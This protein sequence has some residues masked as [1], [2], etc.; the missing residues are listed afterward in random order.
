M[1]K[2]IVWHVAVAPLG[3]ALFFVAQPVFALVAHLVVN[4]CSGATGATGGTGPT[5]VT[6]GTGATG[7]TGPTGP[8]GATGAT[9]GTGGTGPTGA[10]GSSAYEVAVAEGFVGD[11]AAW[12]ASLVGPTGATGAT[13]ATGGTG[14]TGST[15]ATGATGPTGP[16]GAT[17]AAG[18]TGAT[19]ATGGAAD[20]A[21]EIH[22]ATSKAT[23][24]DADELGL[25]DSAAANGLKKLTWANL[26]ATLFAYFQGLFR[27]KLTAART[28][29]VR[30]D[31][32]DS[33]NGLA[34]SSG[35]AFLTIQKAMEVVGNL[36]N[37]TFGVTVQA[38]TGSFTGPVFLPLMVG[39][40][41]LD[42]VGDTTTP[43]NCSISSG[44]VCFQAADNARAIVRGF[45]VSG[46]GGIRAIRGGGIFYNSIDFG[47]CSTY[48]IEAT[49]GGWLQSTG[50]YAIS[51]SSPK[52][53]TCTVLS[54]VVLA[55]GTITLT[56]TPAFSDAFVRCTAV[57]A[58]QVQASAFSGSA[59]GARYRVES[60]AVVDTGG[61]GATY[62]PG[63]AS[64]TVD[65][66]GVY[67]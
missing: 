14:P 13:G 31:G 17:G 62:L 18:A 3:D 55:G 4:V 12:L 6:G 50:S 38:R 20:I 28:Y 59:T 42:I 2:E 44:S 56:G 19:G 40:G 43:S 54:R 46:A 8:T 52:H 39:T 11:E 53:I 45:K 21:A 1:A 67:A 9:G 34:D 57:S 66:T 41:L 58:V 24:V 51:G 30:T 29:Y 32:S 22:A 65:S 63:N 7:G 47:S 49:N 5:G 23:P 33:N 64:G 48:Q 16:T 27:E 61:A 10:T 37:A 25:V 15:G 26:K 60:N 35:G 36:D